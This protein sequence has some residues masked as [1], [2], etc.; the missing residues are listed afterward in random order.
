MASITGIETTEPVLSQTN[1]HTN[2]SDTP[3]LM[4]QEDLYHSQIEAL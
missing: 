3:D 2:K 4:V 1:K